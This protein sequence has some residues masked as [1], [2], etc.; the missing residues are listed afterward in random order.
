M[1]VNILHTQGTG[2]ANW[3]P[4]DQS[5]NKSISDPDINTVLCNKVSNDVIKSEFQVNCLIFVCALLDTTQSLYFFS[6]KKKIEHLH[7]IYNSF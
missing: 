2:P 3:I 4:E 1:D 6:L 5:I 7:Q